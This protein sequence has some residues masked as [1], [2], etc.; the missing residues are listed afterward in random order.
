MG[1]N[2]KLFKKLTESIWEFRTKYNGIQYRFFAFW[3]KTESTETLVI[4]AHGI[5]KKVSKV[6]K[7]DIDKANIIRKEYFN[8]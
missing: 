2:P 8:Q 3:D 7:A 1:N 6:P 4:S 5:I